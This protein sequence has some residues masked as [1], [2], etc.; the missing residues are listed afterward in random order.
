MHAMTYI[1]YLVTLLSFWL[2]SIGTTNAKITTHLR[3]SNSTNK[4]TT[5]H[6]E[7][8]NSPHTQ[9]DNNNNNNKEEQPV[10]VPTMHTFYHR[11]EEENY[12][13]GRKST[14]M[15]DDDD[16]RLLQAWE[17]AWQNAGWNTRVIGMKEAM[18]H[19][20]FANFDQK[21]EDATTADG[22]KLIGYYDKLCYFRWLAMA[23]VGDGWVSDYDTLPLRP[24][25]I[26]PLPYEGRFSLYEYNSVP[27]LASGTKQEYD[28]MAHRLLDTVYENGV[29]TKFWSDMYGFQ[30]LKKEYQI[31]HRVM[32]GRQA[33]SV[34]A[35]VH[36][37]AVDNKNKDN[38]GGCDVII[39]ETWA[40]HFSHKAITE[41][42]K[43]GVLRDKGSLHNRSEIAEMVIRDLRKR[44]DHTNTK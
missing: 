7:G 15:T 36:P 10:P 17:A 42:I 12:F 43:S 31:E 38:G 25:P 28:R 11:I 1:S 37:S 2:T 44:C 26:T 4:E 41:S 40:I 20:D 18:Q 19:P 39:S 34:W 29:K 9:S 6:A 24:T 8:A 22:N 33:L 23:A 14:G 35:N 3:S 30:N 13:R 16:L 21:L 5:P 27:S 32:K